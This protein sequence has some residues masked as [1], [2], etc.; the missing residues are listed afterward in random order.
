MS[1]P[2]DVAVAGPS[3]KRLFLAVNLSIASTRRVA[4]VLD[5][6]RRNTE[7]GRGPKVSWVPPANLHVTLKFLGWARPES[8][9]AL[10]ERVTAGVASRKPFDLEAVGTGAFP[11]VT[12]ARVLW[13]GVR[14]G[15]GALAAL[16]RDVDDW[17]AGL[18][19]DRETRAYHPHVTL[20]RV[21]DSGGADCSEL[22]ASAGVASFGSSSIREVV[23]YESVTT[24]SGSE[25]S[26]LFRA[27]LDA[28]SGHTERQTRTVD[29]PN[30]SRD[31]LRNVPGSSGSAGP[32]GT[33]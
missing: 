16:A 14:D 12:S 15:S 8:V 10:R 17:T 9:L 22:L 7:G 27:P 18:G 30:D 1:E 2:N 26:A 6:L 5:R 21:R 32:E 28:V 19:F 20:G 25:Y 31:E 4:E 33:D 29:L 23:L 24:S 13:V 3:P 11:E